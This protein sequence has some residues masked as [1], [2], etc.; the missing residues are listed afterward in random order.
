MDNWARDNQGSLAKVGQPSQASEDDQTRKG[1]SKGEV[2][3]EIQR[4]GF[5]KSKFQ[6]LPLRKEK[7]TWSLLKHIPTMVMMH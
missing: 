5:F 3:R 1:K 2:Q 6:A 4:A 7:T